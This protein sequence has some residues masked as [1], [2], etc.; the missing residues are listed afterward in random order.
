MFPLLIPMAI[1]AIGGAMANRK[2]PMK[3][4]LLGAGIGATGGLL[5]P[6]GAA[7]AGAASAGAA[8]AGTAAAGGA[9][10]LGTMSQYGKP[11]MQAFSMAQQSGLLNG[12]QEQP[13]QPQPIQ[14]TGGGAQTLMSVAQQGEQQQ[15]YLQQADAER[16]KRRMG[17]LGMEVQ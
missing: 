10:L 17:L 12:G 8:G 3:G 11:A 2:D 15:Q 14:Q 13:M 5:A 4:A 9:G 16:R 1:G 6:A 7:A